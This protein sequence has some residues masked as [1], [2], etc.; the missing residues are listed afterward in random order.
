MHVQ[1]GFGTIN[2]KEPCCEMGFYEEII[3]LI[4]TGKIKDKEELHKFKIRLSSKYGFKKIPKDS[5]IL[6]NLP[7]ILSR[8]EKER[9]FSI[10]RKKPMRTISGVAVV[11]VMTSPASCPHGKCIPCPGGP[12]RNTPQSYTGYEPAA[13]R[14]INNNYDPYLQTKNRLLQLQIVGHPAD[15]IDFIVMGGTFT[16][17][18]IYYQEWFIKRCYDALNKKDSKTLEEAKK[19]NEIAPHR[20]IGLTIETRPDWCRIQHIDNILYYGATRVELGVQTV[21]DDVLYKMGRG[22][23]VTDSI[24]ATKL[25]KNSGLKVCYH[26]MPGLPGSTPDIDIES[27]RTIFNDSKFKPDMIKIYPTLVVKGTKLYE[28]WKNKEY[29][30]LTDEKAIELIAK[31]KEFVPKWVRIQRVERDVPANQIEA[32]VKKSNLRQLVEEKMKRRRKKC[33]CIRCREVGHKI[34][35]KQIKEP[36]SKDNIKIR[37]TYY[38]ASDSWEIFL[39]LEDEKNDAII[40]YLRLRDINES[41]RF[42][43]Q[44]PCMMIR[45]LKILGQEIPIGKRTEYGWQHRGYGKLLIEEAEKIC[46][47]KFDKKDLFVL[48]G[49]GVKTYY[50][51]L[52]FRNNGVY[53]S[54][55]LK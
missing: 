43:L 41:H 44:K 47:E 29:E 50:R 30:P 32:G 25:A 15:K 20:C 24:H 9:I 31:I 28:M 26:M 45:E 39:S 18:S 35:K 2:K 11:A 10:L 8:D 27:F 51:K 6:V 49:V 54:K 52:G 23:T 5:E 16:A 21:F 42:E 19:L 17:R 55:T 46:R 14:A 34:I 36:I 7:K 1:E 40:G 53:L 12:E 4:K 22:H 38:Q 33:N 3:Q 37:T 13:M 48:S